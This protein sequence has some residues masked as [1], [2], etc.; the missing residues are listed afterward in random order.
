VPNLSPSLIAVT[1]SVPAF[2]TPPLARLVGLP[3]PILSIG[4]VDRFY[5]S[6]PDLSRCEGQPTRPNKEMKER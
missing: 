2:L 1:L 3:T 5:S 6:C 4:W